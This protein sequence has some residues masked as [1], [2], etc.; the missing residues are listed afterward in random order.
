[1]VLRAAY[2][3]QFSS[4]KLRVEN[5]PITNNHTVLTMET[6]VVSSRAE[7]S[8]HSIGV[9]AALRI[10]TCGRFFLW[11]PRINRTR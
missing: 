10:A 7:G 2:D 9:L 6:Q 11:N 8:K 4:S 5:I 1:V 3:F